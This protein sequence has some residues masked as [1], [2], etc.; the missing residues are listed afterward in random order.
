MIR[1]RVAPGRPPSAWTQVGRPEPRQGL[2]HPNLTS[3]RSRRFGLE[4]Y[5]PVP[6]RG[7]QEHTS[8]PFLR[9]QQSTQ[10]LFLGPRV[11]GPAFEAFESQKPAEGFPRPPHYRQFQGCQIRERT[12]GLSGSASGRNAPLGGRRVRNLGTLGSAP[13]AY[14]SLFASAP[15]NPPPRSPVRAGPAS[16]PAQRLRG[17]SGA[18][19]G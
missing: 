8:I 7:T 13:P 17:G 15:P 14:P 16:R 12:L 3:R 2:C 19:S 6:F 5:T 9:G 11:E 1:S 18:S 10:F 4:G